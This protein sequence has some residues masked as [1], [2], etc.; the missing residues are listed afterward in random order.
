MTA[1]EAIR[2]GATLFAAEMASLTGGRVGVGPP[3]ALRR[4]MQV[5]VR[6]TDEQWYPATIKAVPARGANNGYTVDYTDG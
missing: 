6:G 4:G 3:K 2:K 5:E 1:N